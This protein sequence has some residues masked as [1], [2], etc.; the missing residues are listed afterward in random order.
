M[1]ENIT[2][3]GHGVDNE[4]LEW[5]AAGADI[6]TELSRLLGHV[7]GGDWSIRVHHIE[8]VKSYA[9]RIYHLVYD[10]ECRPDSN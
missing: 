4:K 1:H 3:T 6:A 2:T 9:P 10:M 7:H 5:G 8:C